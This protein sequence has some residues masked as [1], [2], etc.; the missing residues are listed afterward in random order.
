MLVLLEYLDPALPEADGEHLA[1][2][3]LPGLHGEAAAAHLG[4]RWRGGGGEQ[5]QGEGEE[6]EILS[7]TRLTERKHES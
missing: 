5:E 4:Q 2:G 7:I 1:L 3:G 6:E